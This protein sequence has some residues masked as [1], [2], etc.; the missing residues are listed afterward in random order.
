MSL[1]E[2]PKIQ[3]EHVAQV[4]SQCR[5]SSV[6]P[7]LSGSCQQ[8][9]TRHPTSWH[10]GWDPPAPP[11]GHGC[12]VPSPAWGVPTSPEP[13]DV[14]PE[15][16]VTCLRGLGPCWGAPSVTLPRTLGCAPSS[17][18]MPPL[19]AKHKA[20]KEWSYWCCTGWVVVGWLSNDY[21]A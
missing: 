14:L 10:R 17:T 19:G 13:E 3:A 5:A 6:D 16:P 8:Q 1:L 9:L 12:F 4:R 21:N 7:S 15:V 2:T 20:L 11:A 18:A